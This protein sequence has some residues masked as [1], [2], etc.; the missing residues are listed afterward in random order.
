MYVLAVTCVLLISSD[1]PRCFATDNSRA[2]SNL[3]CE[4]VR[5]TTIAHVGH[6]ANGLFWLLLL[7]LLM[8][9]AAGKS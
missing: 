8:R 6:C 2:L 9:A 5:A 3:L 7:L 4:D 1:A